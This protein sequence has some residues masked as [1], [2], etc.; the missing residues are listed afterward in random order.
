MICR[1]VV[2]SGGEFCG[3]GRCAGVSPL[4]VRRRR[5]SSLKLSAKSFLLKTRDERACTVCR[6]EDTSAGTGL[7]CRVQ[8]YTQALLFSDIGDH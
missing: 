1:N 5:F 3:E 6:G 8:I 7:I 2:R 4:P